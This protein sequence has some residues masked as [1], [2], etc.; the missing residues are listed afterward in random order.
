MLPLLPV[1]FYQERLVA[2]ERVA[3]EPHLP[4]AIAWAA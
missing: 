2:R 3:E 1:M 4:R